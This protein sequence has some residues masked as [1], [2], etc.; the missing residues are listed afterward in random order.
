MGNEL[1]AEDNSFDVI[2]IIAVLH[3]IPPEMIRNYVKEFKRVLKPDGKVVVIE[4]CLFKKSPICNWF[5]KTNDKGEYIQKEEEYLHYFTE[6]NFRCNVLSRFKK[7][8]FYNELYFTAL[9]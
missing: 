1:P 5:M 7:C 4:P 8:F 2:L 6:E 3:H 9:L